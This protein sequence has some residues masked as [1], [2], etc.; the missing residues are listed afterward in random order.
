MLIVVRVVIG[1]FLHSW[2]GATTASARAMV[3]ATEGQVKY[4]LAM[5]PIAAVY[6]GVAGWIERG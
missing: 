2:S 4:R 3:M 5:E 1:C 6:H